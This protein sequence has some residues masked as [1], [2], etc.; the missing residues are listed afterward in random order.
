MATLACAVLA[1]AELGAEPPAD[2]DLVVRATQTI[3]CAAP[4]QAVVSMT[5]VGHANRR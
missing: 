1:Q 3:A 4:D 5:E 2:V